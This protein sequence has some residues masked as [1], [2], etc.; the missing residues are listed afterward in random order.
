MSPTVH[1]RII[2]AEA[3][4]EELVGTI[5]ARCHL[6]KAID[7]FSTVSYDNADALL[8]RVGLTFRF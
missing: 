8:V 5:G 2:T 1:P 6:T 3:A 4:A 7:V